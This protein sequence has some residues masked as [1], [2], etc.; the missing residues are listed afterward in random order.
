MQSIDRF[1]KIAAHKEALG[2]VAFRRAR[3]VVSEIQRTTDAVQALKDR[4]YAAL[5]T[6]MNQ[7]HNSLRSDLILEIFIAD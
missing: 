1:V 4:N 5:G 3:H 7:S 6:L 2:D